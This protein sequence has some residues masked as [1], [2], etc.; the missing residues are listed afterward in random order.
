MA[1]SS[2]YDARSEATVY[3]GSQVSALIK[4]DGV[5]NVP[6]PVHLTSVNFQLS[7]SKKPIYGF[8]S[9]HFDAVAKGQVMVNGTFAINFSERNKLT[10]LLNDSSGTEPFLEEAI[11]NTTK[12]AALQSTVSS[13]L[14]NPTSTDTEANI[15]AIVA[16]CGDPEQAKQLQEKMLSNPMADSNSQWGDISSY[17]GTENE[18]KKMGTVTRNT[19]SLRTIFKYLSNKGFTLT[20]QYGAF[21]GEDDLYIYSDEYPTKIILDGVHVLSQGQ[22]IEVT[23]QPVQ[24]V[25][26]FMARNLI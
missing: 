20:L 26:Q 8:A 1:I 24:E 15:T 19:P 7:Q 2:S 13:I 12:G 22:R 16:Q 18:K 14:A 25:Y 23:G 10:G 11:A 17:D 9:K 5:L 3:S 21:S 6:V 4:A